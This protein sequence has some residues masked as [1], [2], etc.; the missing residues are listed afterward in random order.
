MIIMEEMLSTIIQKLIREEPEVRLT[1]IEI[2]VD[3]VNK[4][5]VKTIPEEKYQKIKSALNTPNNRWTT[6]FNRA[7][8]E[9]DPHVL[10]T[11]RRQR[12]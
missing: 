2:L 3:F 5:G 12:G 11:T 4:Y 7:I 8:D 10:Q 1:Y 6:M 9:T